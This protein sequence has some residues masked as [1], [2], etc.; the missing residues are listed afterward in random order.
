MVKNLAIILCLLIVVFLS[1]TTCKSAPPTW[2]IPPALATTSEEVA[3]LVEEG[4]ELTEVA[5]SINAEY[6]KTSVYAVNC[7]TLSFGSTVAFVPTKE[8]DYYYIWFFLPEVEDQ[9]FLAP[10]IVKGQVTAVFFQWDN[11]KGTDVVIA[12]EQYDFEYILSVITNYG[13]QV[14]WGK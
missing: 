12:V 3:N 8:H 1:T 13:T 4:M 6:G 5:D 14:V 7:E 2:A 11:D 9:G 10:V